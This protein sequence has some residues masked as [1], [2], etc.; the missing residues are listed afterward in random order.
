MLFRNRLHYW[1]VRFF[2]Q[3]PSQSIAGAASRSNCEARSTLEARRLNPAGFF[4][5]APTKAR[6]WSDNKS[7]H[8]TMNRRRPKPSKH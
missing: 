3:L 2:L 5:L 4:F 7:K 6:N 1:H 8:K